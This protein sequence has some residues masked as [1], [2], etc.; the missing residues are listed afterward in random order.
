MLSRLLIASCLLVA[1]SGEVLVLGDGL[2]DS[3]KTK[4]TFVKFYAPVRDPPSPF[5]RQMSQSLARQTR[6]REGRTDPSQEQNGCVIWLRIRD[7]IERLAPACR[8][9]G[10]LIPPHSV[11]HVLLVT[12]VHRGDVLVVHKGVGGTPPLA[13]GDV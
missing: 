11:Q 7:L 1:A 10:G 4:P 6:L 5:H 2:M 12:I 3:V 13:Y 8:E 9:R